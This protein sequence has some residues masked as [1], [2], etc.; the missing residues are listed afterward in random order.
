MYDY[1]KLLGEMRAKNMSQEA[2]ASEIHINPATLNAKLK[3]KTQFRQDEIYAI[4]MALSLPMST[5]EAY[6]F[7]H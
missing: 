6:F 5:V 2:L 4:M 7:A 3:N 1:R